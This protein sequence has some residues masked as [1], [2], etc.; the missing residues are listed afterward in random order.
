[1]KLKKLASLLLALVMALAL[2]VP[3]MA[4]ET[5][6]SIT[7]TGAIPGQKY[8]AYQIFSLES[9]N[10][11]ANAY[12][13]KIV[14]AWK[15]FFNEGAE[16]ATYFTI[17]AQGYATWKAETGETTE[18][19]AARA[20]EFAKKAVAYAAA[21]SISATGTATAG[22]A[23]EG[24]TK[25]D[26]TI[27]P[28]PLGYYVVDSTTGTLC[29]LDTTNPDFSVAEK[30]DSPTIDKEVETGTNDAGQKT[31]GDSNTA[32]IGDTV[33]F[34][35]TITAQK[36]AKDYIFHDTMTE[37]LT[38]DSTSLKV[39]V[40]GTELDSKY[41]TL[42]TAELSDTTCTF[43]VEFAQTYLDTITEPTAIVL[44]YSATLNEK[45]FVGSV[46]GEGETLNTNT[47]KLQYGDKN[48][49]TF[50]PE[51]KTTT[52]TYSFDLVKT[53]KDKKVLTGAQFELYTADQV[54][55]ADGKVTLKDG[56]TAISLIKDEATGNYRVAKKDETG[57]TTIDAGKPT[58]SGLS[59]GTYYL[60]ETK[61]PDG[62]NIL[63]DLQKVEI[64][65][66]NN[67]AT[68][69]EAG[70]TY[71]SGGVQV[72]NLTGAELPSTGG[73]GTT[74]FYIVGGVLAAGAVILLITKRRMN[75]DK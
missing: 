12:S 5:T 61:Q 32:K 35:V 74:I 25:V 50:T 28:L 13:Y 73:I 47:G 62:Y 31:Y 3:A 11:E 49:P 1:M 48:N 15:A 46:P 22:A 36:G 67:S 9:Y 29:I 69:N 6:G 4:E 56:A 14:D 17:D 33:N 55:E 37:G 21:N 39:T 19:Q 52:Y 63:A 59:T 26:V 51:D 40:G 53:D 75:M 41:Y 20:A 42:K 16:G 54:V 44:E 34:K 30:N 45:A 71:V 24:E 60:K 72:I 10:A 57:T 18:T 43:E 64:G 65:S 23:A 38:F 68:L 70:D 66:A 58:I 2:A 8:D 27:N 7:I